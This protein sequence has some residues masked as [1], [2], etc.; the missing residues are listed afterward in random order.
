M[1]FY[2]DKKN[3]EMY[4]NMSKGYDG[5]WLIDEL[6]KHLNRG[7]TLLELGM[8][9]GKDLDILRKEYEVT[10][11]DRSQI[12]IDLYRKK[13]PNI[14]IKKVD[15]VKMNIDNEFDCIYSNKVL[16]HL[17]K[18]ELK[19]SFKNQHRVL[20]K[21]GI[22]FHSFWL[23]DKEEEYNG[24]LFVYY[25]VETLRDTYKDYF[26]MIGSKIYSEFDE[27]DSFFVVFRKK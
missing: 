11:S 15:A 1:D 14:N 21:N 12:F 9:T 26:N 18:D 7:S 19:L 3:V 13:H 25:T 8:G 4:I 2:D 24:L 17:T 22:L 5:K 10:G 20:K 27:D 6:N 23:G 16:H